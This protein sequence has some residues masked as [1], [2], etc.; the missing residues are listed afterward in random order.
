MAHPGCVVGGGALVVHV[1]QCNGGCGARRF[2]VFG[3][4]ALL[5]LAGVGCDTAE[6]LMVVDPETVYV[7]D[8]VVARSM[9]DGEREWR[10]RTRPE[11]S[12]ATLVV[13]RG[14]VA[15]FVADRVG[16]YVVEV[17][18]VDG[19]GERERDVAGAVVEALPRPPALQA[20]IEGP[21]RAP[22]GTV[23]ELD[24]SR[25][26]GARFAW[27]WVS[28]PEWSESELRT[29]D[30]A[31]TTFRLDEDGLFV[32]SL[33]VF[34]DDGRSASA[35][36]SVLV[37][38]GPADAAPQA[39]IA[40][41]RPVLVGETVRLNGAASFDPDGTVITFDWVLED[42]PLGSRA[43]LEYPTTAFPELT[44]DVAGVYEVAL[45]VGDATG[46]TG[47]PWTVSVDAANPA[48][49]VVPLGAGLVDAAYARSSDLVLV[50]DDTATVWSYGAR[51]GLV[52]S[53]TATGATLTPTGGT[54][55]ATSP[56]GLTALVAT[57]SGVVPIDLATMTPRE[58]I[59]TGFQPFSMVMGSDR[60]AYVFGGGWRGGMYCVNLELGRVEP[61]GVG[62]VPAGSRA[63]LHPD[64]A[65]LY[66][67]GD[68][69]GYRFDVSGA[70]ATLV[71]HVPSVDG[72]RGRPGSFSADG[73]IV[74]CAVLWTADGTHEDF[75]YAG[76][77]ALPY[78]WGNGFQADVDPW[79]GRIAAVNPPRL[80]GEGEPR[81]YVFDDTYYELSTRIA[82]PRLPDGEF[83]L[84]QRVYFTSEGRMLVLVRTAPGGYPVGGSSSVMVLD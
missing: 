9:G 38:P 2:G 79:G 29:P 83:A 67:F 71:S 17:A 33:T 27:E 66:A 8:L 26:E 24:G 49:A 39:R 35:T 23:V 22:R 70:T 48:R 57:E 65:R 73:R 21:S 37:A 44:P 43:V 63:I 34:G 54:L 10:L 56:S 76:S 20:R 16:R 64:G 50:L 55:L 81:V 36:H 28:R 45:T 6:T 60:W 84:A 82:L 32:V 40:P 51:S 46:L 41:V 62:M 7:G 59:A 58:P 11:D 75:A 4:G 18:V 31:M 68:G 74:S 52:R 78:G 30:G 47:G 5:A 77:L 19:N 13:V 69:S 25:S 12:R 1:V 80:A 61:C 14:N 3:L 42:A 15:Q 53:L 72:C